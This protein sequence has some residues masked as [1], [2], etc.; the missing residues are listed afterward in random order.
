MTKTR[1]DILPSCLDCTIAGLRTT[2]RKLFMKSLF[3]GLTGPSLD[4]Q[5]VTRKLPLRFGSFCGG[6]KRRESLRTEIQMLWQPGNP[7]MGA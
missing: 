7:S 4:R 5:N 1:E 3:V 2:Y 6:I